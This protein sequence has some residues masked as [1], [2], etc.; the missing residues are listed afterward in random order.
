[1]KI[2]TG[3][4]SYRQVSFGGTWL[5]TPYPG[6]TTTI[7]RKWLFQIKEFLLME[8][9]FVSSSE[10]GSC[11]CWGGLHFDVLHRMEFPTEWG[12]Q[13]GTLQ[14]KGEVHRPKT[15][16]VANIVSEN[17]LYGGM[18]NLGGCSLS[19]IF[20]HKRPAADPLSGLDK[21]HTY[22]TENHTHYP[23]F[24]FQSIFT[25]LPRYHNSLFPL[26]PFFV[27]S[28]TFSVIVLS[29]LREWIISV[30]TSVF[31]ACSSKMNVTSLVIYW[32]S[33]TQLFAYSR[34]ALSRLRKRNETRNVLWAHVAAVHWADPGLGNGSE[35]DTKTIWERCGLICD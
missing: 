21:A 14:G 31:T 17:E 22:R 34:C 23:C 27:N 8:N 26:S 2:W 19:S 28:I 6:P 35:A 9:N 5:Y 20:S 3:E 30:F 11:F 1:M 7:Y 25:S 32:S 24:L 18:V 16:L 4:A 15:N 12:F 13:W 29:I 33:T 10:S